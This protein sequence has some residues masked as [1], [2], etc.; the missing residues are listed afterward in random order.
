MFESLLNAAI[1]YAIGILLIFLAN[2][3]GGILNS[4]LVYVFSRTLGDAAFYVI[5]Y[6]MATPAFITGTLLLVQAFLI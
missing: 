5:L 3:I 6:G 4:F 2:T 1:C